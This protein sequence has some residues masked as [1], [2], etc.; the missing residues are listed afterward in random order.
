MKFLFASDSFK[1]TLSSKRTA[2]LLAQAASEI[3]PGCEYSSI[4]VADGGEGTTDAVLSAVNGEK[5]AV[6]VHGPLWEEIS[7]YY[8]KLDDRR[9]VME[10]AAASGLPLVPSEQRDPR[11]TTSYGTGEMIA[12]ALGKGFRDISI[13]IGGSA[14]NDGGIGCMRALGVRFLDENGQE[15]SGCGADL[16]EIR[17]IDVSGLDPRVKECKFTVMCDVTNPLCGEKG[18]THT[19]GKQ[20]GGTPEILEELEKGMCNYRDI[21]KNQFGVNMDEV[22]GAGAAG[23]LGA[24]LMVFLNGTL[25]SG[26]ETVLDLVEF[27]RK[28]EGVSLVVTGE[29]STDWQSVFGKVMQG[30]GVHCRKA[31]IP[32]VAVV[33]SMGKGAEDIFDYGIESILTTVNA[34]MPLDEA[35]GRAEELYLQA[36]RRMFRMLRAGREMKNV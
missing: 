12:D 36:A 6:S 16:A 10:M 18:A 22:P 33:G 34:V 26:I 14:T 2:E 15:L 30:V 7:A 8:G 32:A 20:K 24:A 28:L 11:K 9:A 31:G 3:F 23:G 13:A 17:S 35:L 5:I 25:K 29:G 1:G 21:L 27:D 19:F 4:E